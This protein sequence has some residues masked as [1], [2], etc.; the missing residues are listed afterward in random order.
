MS[1]MGS[2]I[3]VGAIVGTPLALL[4]LNTIFGVGAPRD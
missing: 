1:R 3:I 4:L 2:L